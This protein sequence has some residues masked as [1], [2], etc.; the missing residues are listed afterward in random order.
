M[1]TTPTDLLKEYVSSQH[2]T[3]T[4]EVMEAMKDSCKQSSK[5]HTWECGRFF[6]PKSNHV[7]YWRG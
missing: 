6:G 7:R 2:F 5:M 4:T 3:S 1:N